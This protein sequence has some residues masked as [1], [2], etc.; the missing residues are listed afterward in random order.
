MQDAGKLVKN[1]DRQVDPLA[2]DLKKTVKEF[3]KLA[4]NVD[5]QVGGLATGLDKTMAEARGF[6]SEDSPLI[7]ELENTLKEISAMSRSFRHLANYLEQHPEV[8]IRGKA[9][10]L[11]GNNMRVT[12]FSRGLP[13]I[14]AIVA[15]FLGGCTRSQTPRFYTLTPMHQTR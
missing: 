8:L 9:K 2:N 11:E 14:L 10:L 7:V 4:N 13:V 3:G 1:V 5:A 12:P 15:I 6:L